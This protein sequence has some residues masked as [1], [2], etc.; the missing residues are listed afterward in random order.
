MAIMG[1]VGIELTKEQALQMAD[2]IPLKLPSMDS[3]IPEIKLELQLPDI[4][5][6]V[7]IGEIKLPRI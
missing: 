6:L 5:N 2:I 1:K 3:L 4:S 7:N